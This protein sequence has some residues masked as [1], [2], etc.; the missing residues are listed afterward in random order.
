MI[1]HEDSTA[2]RATVAQAC[3]I[4]ARRGLVQGIL[5][6][7]SAR[8]ADDQ[9]VVRCRGPHDP[10]LARTQHSDIWRVSLEGV[11]VDMPDGYAVPKELPLHA[12]ILRRRPNV[13]AVVHAHPRSALLCGLAGLEPRAVFGAFDIPAARLAREGLPVYPRPVL[14]A[15]DEIAAE[16]AT[17]MG[18]ANQCLL[19][20]HGVVVAGP[21][22][23]AATLRA[24]DLD[25]LLG[26]T[27]DLA[28]L[29]AV[30]DALPAEDWD[31][32]PDLGP[33]F[34]VVRRWEALVSSLPD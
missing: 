23:E 31:D 34:N 27:V 5:G 12:E 8:V 14:V 3:R 1:V 30:P 2:L 13:G 20:G 24:V 15:R 26:I 4:L 17:V 11:P 10:G 28:R 22:V 21:T 18:D 16:I 7:V 32:L 6:H 29:G 25:T 33:A 19:R 9:M